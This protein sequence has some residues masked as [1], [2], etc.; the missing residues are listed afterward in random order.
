MRWDG[1]PWRVDAAGVPSDRPRFRRYLFE[2]DA[3]C[4][5]EAE[6]R[7]G[8]G[9]DR[10]LVS[11]TLP[12]QQRQGVVLPDEEFP[13]YGLRALAEPERHEQA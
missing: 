4:V 2:P 8:P 7:E 13:V 6:E 9:G 3:R 5:G 10:V 11:H 12:D 1:A